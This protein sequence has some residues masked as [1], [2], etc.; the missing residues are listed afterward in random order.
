MK[1]DGSVLEKK[2]YFEVLGLSSRQIWKLDRGPYIAS[3]AKTASKKIGAKTLFIFINI[4]RS[5]A[6]NTVDISG[7][8]FLL[9]TWLC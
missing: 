8:V 4:P 5:F 2:P 1:I 6:W 3:I 9:D 7:L